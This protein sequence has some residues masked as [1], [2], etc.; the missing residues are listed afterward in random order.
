MNNA[1]VLCGGNLFHG[2]ER[3]CHVVYQNY[4]GT[5]RAAFGDASRICTAM[6]HD[7]GRDAKRLSGIR[8]SDGVIT[9]TDSRDTFPPFRVVPGE[10]VVHCTPG[11]E[12]AR[13]L[14]EFELEMEL[15]V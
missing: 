8:N 11:L 14:Q 1:A 12:A 13:A 2:R 15:A 6:H 5:E 3:L 10:N 9:G 7:L 4:F